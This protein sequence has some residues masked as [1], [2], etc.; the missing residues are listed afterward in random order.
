MHYDCEKTS[1]VYISSSIVAHGC[2]WWNRYAFSPYRDVRS[3]E[4]AGAIIG[5]PTLFTEGVTTQAGKL[6]ELRDQPTDEFMTGL[7]HLWCVVVHV[8]RVSYTKIRKYL[9]APSIRLNEKG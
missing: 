2:K 5:H 9:Y 1:A 6:V 4:H 3:A 7:D 8:M